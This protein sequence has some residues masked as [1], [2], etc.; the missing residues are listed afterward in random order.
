LLSFESK[1]Y[2][3]SINYETIYYNNRKV[4]INPGLEG[5]PLVSTTIKL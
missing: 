1:Y 4:K 3:T 2:L 5:Q